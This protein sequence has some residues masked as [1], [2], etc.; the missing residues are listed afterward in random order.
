MTKG[1]A[2]GF[3]TRIAE[4]GLGCYALAMLALGITDGFTNVIRLF[5]GVALIAHTL[6]GG[7][8]G[9]VLPTGY[10]AHWFAL[11][12]LRSKVA[13]L[14]LAHSRFKAQ[15]VWSTRNTDRIALSRLPGFV[16]FQTLASIGL[17][18][19]LI[20]TTAWLAHWL[21][22]GTLGVPLVASSAFTDFRL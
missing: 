21:T 16:A 7:L 18:A 5:L 8:A 11:L 10:A 4:T 6:L 9:A 14:A 19:E 12:L 3:V 2:F 1:C 20:G 17:L 15:T 22:C 13:F